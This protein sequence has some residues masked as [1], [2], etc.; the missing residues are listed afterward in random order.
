MSLLD[1]KF[2]AYGYLEIAYLPG[3]SGPS[4]AGYV[5]E[6]DF[7]T[8]NNL[9]SQHNLSRREPCERRR[10]QTFRLQRYFIDRGGYL[11]PNGGVL[12]LEPY[13]MADVKLIDRRQAC[14]SED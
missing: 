4:S 11:Q 13:K 5:L 6:S 2:V 14:A 12:S 1:A 8:L 9:V 10:G 7:E 3:Q